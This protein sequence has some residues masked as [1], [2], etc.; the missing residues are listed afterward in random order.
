MKIRDIM[1]TNVACAEPDFTLDEVAAMMRDEDT[2]IIPVV[3]E[4]ELI[5]VITAGRQR[6]SGQAA[7]RQQ[8]RQQKVTAI[9]PGG[10]DRGRTTSRRKA[11]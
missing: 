9:R 11:S 7:Q 2:G 3:E 4:D 8:G 1:T 6:I 5:G 10:K